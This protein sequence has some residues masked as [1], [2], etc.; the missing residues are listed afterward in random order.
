MRTKILSVALA[1][2]AVAA[3]AAMAAR[4]ATAPAKPVKPAKPAKPV[5]SYLFKGVV[6]ANASSDK[7]EVSP[8]KGTNVFAR[9]ALAGAA[10]IGA[11]SMTLKIATTTKLK[12]RV[13]AADGTK[14]F[15]PETHADLMA[16]DVVFFHIRAPKGTA[17]ADLPAAKWIRD[18]T[19][20][21]APAPAPA[22]TA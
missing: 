3:P 13:V 10:S 5:V 12:S 4:P 16:G 17:A 21:P 19:A 15:V 22:P 14:S 2:G 20:N 1:V 6:L 9:R 18:L 11:A 8:V 7:V